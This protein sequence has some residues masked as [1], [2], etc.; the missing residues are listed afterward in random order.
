MTAHNGHFAIGSVHARRTL[1]HKL[2]FLLLFR[3]LEL[4]YLAIGCRL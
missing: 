4:A 2:M 1:V 3:L